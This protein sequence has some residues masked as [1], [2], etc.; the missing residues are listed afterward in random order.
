MGVWCHFLQFTVPTLLTIVCVSPFGGDYV[1]FCSHQTYTKD[2]LIPIRFFSRVNIRTLNCYYT[3]YYKY[4]SIKERLWGRTD[5]WVWNCRTVLYSEHKELKQKEK[6]NRPFKK[7]L[8]LNENN[9]LKER[10][11]YR[12]FTWIVTKQSMAGKQKIN[13]WGV[14]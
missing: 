9:K 5:D 14:S 8:T 10:L 13:K 7:Q 12:P 11:W 3:A 6:D 2:P 4:T 1:A